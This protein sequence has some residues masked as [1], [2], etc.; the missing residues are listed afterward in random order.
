M[1][2]FNKQLILLADY[3]HKFDIKNNSFPWLK[4]QIK[5]KNII[6][7]GLTPGPEMQLAIYAFET[8]IPFMA[9]I[10]YKNYPNLWSTSHKNKYYNLLKK[11]VKVIHVD[12]QLGFMSNYWPPDVP[13]KEKENNQVAWLMKRI[14]KYPGITKVI[15]YTHRF[16]SFKNKNLQFYLQGEEYEGKWHLTQRTHISL[17]E[18]LEDDLPF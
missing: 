6:Y 10:P 9:V 17:D 16:H 8:K 3:S 15:S 1:P 5:D 7:T 18:T 2:Y 4:R 14:I 11:A 13:A 12:R